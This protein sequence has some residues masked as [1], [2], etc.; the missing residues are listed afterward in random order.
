MGA[1]ATLETRKKDPAPFTLSRGVESLLRPSQVKGTD[2]A[3]RS[4]T[5][6]M[7]ED[8]AEPKFSHDFSRIPTLTPSLSSHQQSLQPESQSCPM[9]LSDSRTCPFGGACHICPARVQTKLAINQPGD[10]Y[11]QEADRV[12]EHVMGIAD[13]PVHLSTTASARMQNQEVQRECAKCEDDEEALQKKDRS[14]QAAVLDYSSNVPPIVHE[15]L[16]SPGQPLDAVTRKFFE[17]RFDY[18]FSM[19]RV[20]NDAKA[21]ASAQ[22][23]NAKA[24]TVGRHIVFADAHSLTDKREGRRL[25]AHELTHLLQQNSEKTIGMQ[26]VLTTGGSGVN[27]ILQREAGEKNKECPETHTVPDDVHK[28]IGEAWAESGHGGKTVA[29]HGGRIVTDKEGKRVI[30]T[31]KGEPGSISLPAEK[32]SDITLGTFHTHPY[33]KS[34]GAMQGV[35]FSGGDISNFIAGGQGRAKYVGAGTCIFAIV[36]LDKEMQDACKKL[37]INKRW[38]DAFSAASG[39]FQQKVKKSVKSAIA[40]CGICFYE[41]CKKGAKDE[42]PKTAN[43]V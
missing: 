4:V 25:L 35:G 26:S 38:T 23:V 2:G 27:S 32:P 12:A 34:E 36:T 14:G 9:A 6:A 40:G 22:A 31:G 30:R 29:E 41:A 11:E 13:L 5:E 18:D 24:Y 42:I 43:L 33:S 8:R 15:V 17:P 20:H 28:A 19:V 39:T 16:R 10:E 1:S 7:R 21:T 37:D 3:Q